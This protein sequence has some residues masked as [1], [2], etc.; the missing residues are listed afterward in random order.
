[1]RFSNI[2]TLV[3]SGGEVTIGGWARCAA[4]QPLPMK[5]NRSRCLHDHMQRDTRSYMKA[6]T[7]TILLDAKIEREL[8]RLSRQLGRSR[9]NIVWDTIRRQVAV[10]RFERSRRALLPLAET[11][12]ILTD[13]DVFHL[14]S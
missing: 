5:T 2:A 9:S 8:T 3:S 11:Q 14:V 10:L 1:M 12:G 4:V 7:I 13:E 6:S